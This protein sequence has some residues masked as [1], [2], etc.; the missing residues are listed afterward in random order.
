MCVIIFAMQEHRSHMRSTDYSSML[1]TFLCILSS[2]SEIIQLFLLTPTIS[3]R[4]AIQP[5]PIY[6][7]NKL[8]SPLLGKWRV[9]RNY[10]VNIIIRL[11]KHVSAAPL[12][13][14]SACG[15]LTCKSNQWP[16]ILCM[17]ALSPCPAVL[18]VKPRGPLTICCC[19]WG[20]HYHARSAMPAQ[21][22]QDQAL[23]LFNC[24]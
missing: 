5:M 9:Q 18:W 7:P 17:A 4:I 24:P 23:T 8:Q 10:W 3:L 21:W 2:T 20:W 12:S 19:H 16:C 14:L 13:V 15:I 22:A 1:Y 11:L 6:W